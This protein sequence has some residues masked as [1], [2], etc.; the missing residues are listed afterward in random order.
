MGD[1]KKETALDKLIQE[2][3]DEAVEKEAVGDLDEFLNDDDLDEEAFEFLDDDA[4]TEALLAGNSQ[5]KSALGKTVAAIAILALLGGGAWLAWSY[6]DDMAS[7]LK[8]VAQQVDDGSAAMGEAVTNS[9]PQAFDDGAGTTQQNANSQADETNAAGEELFFDFEAIS[10][11]QEN[12]ARRTENGD[13]SDDAAMLASP[14]DYVDQTELPMDDI[15][16][17]D[18]IPVQD[19]PDQPLLDEAMLND[20][21]KIMTQEPVVLEVNEPEPVATP[22]SAQPQAS[23]GNAAAAQAS[24]SKPQAQKT[25]ATTQT[26]P[27]PARPSAAEEQRATQ[28]LNATATLLGQAR[29][30]QRQGKNAQAM[31]LYQEIL[32]L[33]PNH[34]VALPSYQKLAA[35]TQ[36]PTQMPAVAPSQ[37][38]GL[39]TLETP[40]TMPAPQATA[41]G[42]MSA[43]ERLQKRAQGATQ[44]G[45]T[46]DVL[47]EVVPQPTNTPVSQAM[48]QMVP[49]TAQKSVTSGNKAQA[50]YREALQADQAGQFARAIDLYQRALEVDAVEYDGRSLDRGGVYDRLYAIRQR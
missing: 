29:L 6:K 24:D 2:F 48:P 15:P 17:M 39:S 12:A 40:S 27:R 22:K 31:A 9:F 43:I 42:R 36:L 10:R 26:T 1:D 45:K 23:A 34:P 20:T 46:V 33:V 21:I 7:G 49:Q 25:V 35:V 18:A 50:L 3:D 44:P 30:A 37:Q 32:S 28:T 5:G 38:A 14:Q 41:A 16:S 19:Y 8:T 11:E 47:D 13:A 4:E